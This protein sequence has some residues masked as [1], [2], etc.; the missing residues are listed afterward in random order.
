MMGKIYIICVVLLSVLVL[1]GCGGGVGAPGSSGGADAGVI[2]KS[3]VM[4]VTSPD[5]NAFNLCEDG[6][7]GPGLKRTDATLTISAVPL[8]AGATDD[9]FPLTLQQCTITYLKA[10]EDPA[11]P[12][13]ETFTI[14]PD[15]PLSNGSTDCPVTLMDFERKFKWGS[16]VSLGT[17]SPAESATHYVAVGDCRYMTVF[18]KAGT[19]KTQVDIWLGWFP[20]C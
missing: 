11:S 1:V 10:N 5:I 6:T 15:C 19:F 13:I 7:V 20:E 9:P 3:A 8:V 18:G 12:I 17:F 16:D 4:T 2:I 14:Y